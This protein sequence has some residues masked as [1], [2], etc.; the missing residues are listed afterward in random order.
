MNDLTTILQKTDDITGRTLAE[1]AKMVLFTLGDSPEEIKSA[2]RK[3]ARKF[4]PDTATGDTELFQLINE[5]FILLTEGK[6]PKKPLLSDDALILKVTGLKEI[7]PLLDMQK[8]WEEY[9]RAHREQF[10]GYGV[11]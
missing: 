4:H 3:L 1:R 5:A 9:E 8:E 11:I 10:Y 6:I 7:A 2:Y